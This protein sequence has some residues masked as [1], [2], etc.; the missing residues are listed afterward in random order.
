MTLLGVTFAV[1]AA[2]GVLALLKEDAAAVAAIVVS[3]FL[4]LAVATYRVR[5][6]LKWKRT[7]GHTFAGVADSAVG[8]SRQTH[9]P[10]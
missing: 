1:M 9:V 5:I 10:M 3:A 8:R 6:H 7:P 4:L 2:A